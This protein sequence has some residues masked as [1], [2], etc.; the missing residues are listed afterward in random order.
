MTCVGLQI[1]EDEVEMA[2]P[3]ENVVVK[4]KGVEEEDVHGGFVLSHIKKPSKVGVSF[5]AQVAVLDLLEHKPLVTVGYSAILHIHSLSIPCSI[6]GLLSTVDRKTG[7]KKKPR[8]LRSG[9]IGVVR[10]TVDESICVEAYKDFPQM[11]RFTLRDEGK[12][13]GIGKV[14]KVLDMDA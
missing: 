1:D 12:T 3:G 6:S 9:D 7:K 8:F 14:N 2:E 11:G 5:N 10:I 13:I 4:V